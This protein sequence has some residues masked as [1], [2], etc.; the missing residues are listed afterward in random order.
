MIHKRGFE[1]AEVWCPN[2]DHRIEGLKHEG[3]VYRFYT[4]TYL[5]NDKSRQ[6]VEREK[7]GIEDNL[8]LKL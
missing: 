2:E 4:H 3:D 5:G 7:H 6:S 1:L 8:W